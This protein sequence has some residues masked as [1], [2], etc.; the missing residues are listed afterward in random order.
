V[1]KTKV[2]GRQVLADGDVI[3]VGNANIVFSEGSMVTKNTRV[4]P[5]CG[6]VR[7]A[8]AKFCAKCGSKAV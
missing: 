4:C 3:N 5:S 8:G 1:N 2:L 7:R 6:T